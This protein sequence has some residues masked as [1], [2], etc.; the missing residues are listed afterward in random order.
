MRKV[1]KISLIA[2]AL[3]VITLIA[4]P[5]VFK[6]K[7]MEKVKSEANKQ[8]NATLAFKDV[9]LSVFRNFPN[10]TIGIEQFSL[11]GQNEFA[12]D[13]LFAAEDFAITTDIMSV[14]RGTEIQVKSIILEKGN[15]NLLVTE[16]GKVNWDIMKPTETKP[17]EDKA[18]ESSAF[19]VAL[20]KLSISETNIIYNDKQSGLLTKIKKLNHT[21]K[22]DL[23]ADFTNL[24]TN[25]T[26]EA[27]TFMYGSV[28]YL[29]NVTV[30]YKAD[31]G[32]DLKNS[33]YEFKENEL[34]IND[35]MVKLSG[36]IEMPADDI[37]IDLNFEAIKNEFKA[38]LSLV[39]NAYNESFKDLKSGGNLSFKG[40]LKGIYNEKSM[41]GYGIDLN[42]ENGM[43]QYPSL[44]RSVSDVQVKCKIDCP[45]GVPDATVI[46]APKIHVNLGQ[47]PID[48]RL[49]VTT[50]VSDANIDAAVKGALNLASVK[51]FF[52]LDAST[53]L[54]GDVKADISAKGR[55]SS[56]DRGQYEQFQLDGTAS[57]A[58]FNYAAKDLA[59]PINIAIADM[60]FNPKA[61]ELVQLK[62]KTGVSDINANG[63]IE[64]HLAYIFRDEPVKGQLNL[65]SNLL[66]LNPFLT[67]ET[68]TKPAAAT[69]PAEEV[70]G[71][72]RVPAN[73][74]FTVNATVGKLIYDNMNIDNVKGQ[75]RIANQTVSM[76]NLA[77]NLLGGS[78]GLNGN[79]N[80]QKA[81]GP[82]VDL[83]LDVKN[84]NIKQTAKTF[85]TVKQLAPI[86]ENTV[87]NVSSNFNLRAE[88]D[89]NFNFDYNTVNASGSFATSQIVIE[90][91]EMVKKL[92]ETLK[93]DKLKKWQMEKLSGQFEIVS[94]KLF[95]K[96]FDTK[97]GNYKAKIAGSNGIDQNIDYVMNIEIPKNEFG[98]AANTVLN[99]LVAQANAKGIQGGIP[100]IIPVDVFIT[101]TFSNPK[102]KTSLKEKG[103][104][105]LNDLKNQAEQKAREEAEKLKQQAQAEIDKKKK[106]IE[107]K[108]NAEKDKLKSEAEKAKAEAER[109]AKEEADKAKEKAKK[110]AENKIK[111]L[112][113][114]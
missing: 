9:S 64:N 3:I 83:K 21:A 52:P 18:S 50:P 95:V 62:L 35:L 79:Y 24:I 80:T 37:K 51:E 31:F 61:V 57:V 76:N 56:I 1:I 34:G 6:G 47:F 23:T 91:F 13:T 73:V 8:L 75:L 44:P 10:V 81:S 103:K 4:I 40:Y 97:I 94:G 27:L 85:N 104:D 54:N 110:D 7:I 5:F 48:A 11:I 93:I 69:A 82:Q 72:I 30:D 70:M 14:I 87:G 86:A 60:K 12:G 41:P 90:G 78:L 68:G 74:D 29:K 89:Q 45:S 113:G 107:D 100:D 46:D 112:F 63:K 42:I 98:G 19:K 77:M 66:N 111:G 92:A 17:T 108:V 65:S 33:I 96:P 38:F 114:K 59:Q 36:K 28:A 99:N 43:F 26:I 25:T 109:K 106:E 101:G 58:N 71:Y 22:G 55:M 84:F 15:I 49:R 102:V 20:K 32:L 39:P 53:Q 88:A 67:A 16:T 105:A 2:L